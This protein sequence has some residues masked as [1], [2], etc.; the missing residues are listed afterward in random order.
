VHSSIKLGQASSKNLPFLKTT[1]CFCNFVIIK[2]LTPLLFPSFFFFR[3]L[4]CLPSQSCH[5]LA[6]ITTKQSELF[7]CKTDLGQLIMNTH[8]QTLSFSLSHTLS[9]THTHTFKVPSSSVLNFLH[10]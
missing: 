1:K 4:Y 8:T 5:L 10:N 7:H 6:F 9:L 2:C 3:I